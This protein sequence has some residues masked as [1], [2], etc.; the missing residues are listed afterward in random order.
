MES[1]V[2]PGGEERREVSGVSC[3]TIC[4]VAEAE[5]VVPAREGESV[6]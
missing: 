5:T 4:G 3:W 2:S 6:R 1:E